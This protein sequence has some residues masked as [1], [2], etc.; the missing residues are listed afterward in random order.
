MV[1]IGETRWCFGSLRSPKYPAKLDKSTCSA[2]R[3]VHATWH[4]IFICD[5]IRASEIVIIWVIVSKSE[6][7]VT[8][9]DRLNGFKQIVIGL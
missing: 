2:L 4:I 1:R 6:F 3:L 7:L 5:G 8:T 9:I